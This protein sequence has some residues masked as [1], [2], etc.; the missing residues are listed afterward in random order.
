MGVSAAPPPVDFVRDV[1]P[2]LRFGGEDDW[3]AVDPQVNTNVLGNDPIEA[4]DLGLR[5]IDRVMPMLIPGTTQPG[6]SYARMAEMYDALI[7]LR[8][9][10]LMAV[11]KLVGGVEE[12]RYQAGRGR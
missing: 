4:A 12:T 9:R 1:Q 6:G 5:N 8:H 2:M 3:A 11:A 10:E 7:V